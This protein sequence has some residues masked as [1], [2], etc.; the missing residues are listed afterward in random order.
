MAGTSDQ[1]DIWLLVEYPDQWAAKFLEHPHLPQSLCSWI[2]R[3]EE[4]LKLR[5]WKVRAQLI[6]RNR[7]QK[8]NMSA[9]IAVRESLYGFSFSRYDHLERFDLESLILGNRLD[10]IESL[11]DPMYFVCTHGLRDNCC[12]KFGLPV[13]RELE[14][15][16]QDR[17]WQ[18]THLGG[19]RFAPNVLVLPDGLLYGRVN[20]EDLTDFTD[21]VENKKIAFKYLRGRSAYRKHVQA[22][23]VLSRTDGFKFLSFSGNEKKSKVYFDSPNGKQS[24]TVFRQ[25]NYEVLASCSDGEKK[26]VT[27]YISHDEQDFPAKSS[28]T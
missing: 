15:K 23:E 12:G 22:A 27:H 28:V 11:S 10:Q 6:R 1:V 17:V 14:S 5:G 25:D 16:Y 8:D 19:H 2:K 3:T 21:L 26:T 13:Y 18:T 4:T 7:K 24:I 20:L 9:F